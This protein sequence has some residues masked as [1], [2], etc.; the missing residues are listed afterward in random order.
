MPSELASESIFLLI[1]S[2]LL[3]LSILIRGWLAKL[4]RVPPVVGFLILGILLRFGQQQ[5]GFV[6]PEARW[7]L[8]FFAQ[9]GVAA[10]LFRVGLR[11]NLD[12][13]LRQ[14]PRATGIWISNVA[15]SGGLGLMAGWLLGWGLIPSAFV[16]VAMSATSVGISVSIWEQAKLTRSKL[17]ELLLDVAELDDV[18]AVLLMLALLAAA[19]ILY[20]QGASEAAVVAAAAIGAMLLKV[21]AFVVG[22]WV[23]AK[24]LEGPMSSFLARAETPPDRI[25]TVLAVGLTIAAI[26]GWIGFS[27]AVG[28]LFAGL[29]FSRDRGAVRDEGLLEPI[30]G[31]FTPFFFIDIGYALDLSVLGSSALLGTL[32]FVPAVLGKVL[33][34]GLPALHSTGRRGALILGVS[35]V[36][37]AEI[38]L[39]IARTGNRLGQWAVPDVVYG[40]LV[41]AF[42]LTAALAPI[43]L[44]QLFRRWP[45]SVEDPPRAAGSA[46]PA[47]SETPTAQE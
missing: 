7:T 41:V 30:Y 20:E 42:G 27:I 46:D 40:A 29:A 6:F 12:G 33:G 1:I 19:P 17:G 15:I 11:S 39:V 38:A 16:A 10:L 37:R 22:C 47:P 45:K 43:V 31:F 24:Y 44:E 14:L 34:T 28:A 21:A 2:T 32:L 18:S 25:L 36:P 5:W 26:A 4:A 35:M 8:E 13:L 9:L 3:G 23:F